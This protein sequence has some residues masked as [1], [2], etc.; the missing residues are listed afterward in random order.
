M[1]LVLQRV[2]SA[3][4][5]V[6]GLEIVCIGEGLLIFVGFGREDEPMAEDSEVIRRMARKVVQ[7]RVFPDDSGRL[8]ASLEK[9]RGEILA[10]SQFTL[11]A[12]CSK[13]RRPTLHGAASP[14][15]ALA[16]FNAFVLALDGL[17]P[18]RVRTGAFGAQMDVILH[19]WGPLTF[20]WDSRT[21]LGGS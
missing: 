20:F 14:P 8:N 12:D 19:N 11:H 17:L 3:R 1:R 2:R 21:M 4:V 15:K 13:G 5:E 7:A 6:D 9:T 16:L 18:E 10:V